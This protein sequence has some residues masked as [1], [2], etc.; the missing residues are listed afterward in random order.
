MPIRTRMCSS[1]LSIAISA[2][3]VA[4]AAEAQKARLPVEDFRPLLVNA[5]ES[6]E[7]RAFGILIGP[8]AEALTTRMKA[9]SPIL[10]DVTTL[11]R[12]KQAGCSRL[13]VRFS[14]DG[15]VLPGTDKPRKQTFD[16]GLNYCRDGQPPRSLA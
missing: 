15:V 9:T 14:Q 7:G 2:I 3:F 13:N 12:Y 10:I 1:I 5:I 4:P 11:R 16:L 6:A 8:M